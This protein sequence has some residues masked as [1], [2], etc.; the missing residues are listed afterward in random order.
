MNKNIEQIALDA[1]IPSEVNEMMKNLVDNL[2]TNAVTFNTDHWLQSGHMD[3]AEFHLPFDSLF[4]YCKE[5]GARIF[6]SESPVPILK[7]EDEMF[8]LKNLMVAFGDGLD[9]RLMVSL[10]NTGEIEVYDALTMLRR[11]EA[12]DGFEKIKAEKENYILVYNILSTID[13]IN[14]ADYVTTTK[15]EKK[16]NQYSGK[17]EYIFNTTIKLKRKQSSGHKTGTGVKHKYRYRV[18]GHWRTLENGKRIWV[19][20]HVRGGDGTLFIPKEYEM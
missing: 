4:I 15:R 8:I 13:Y 16:T 19:K 1:G 9:T 12:G 6:I 3:V 2:F 5:F 14:N 10:W 11:A 18:R 7:N 20:N 17:R